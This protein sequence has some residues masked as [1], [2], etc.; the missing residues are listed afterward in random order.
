MVGFVAVA[1]SSMFTLF[2][3]ISEGYSKAAGFPGDCAREVTPTDESRKGKEGCFSDELKRRTRGELA[4][5]R[6]PSA[7]FYN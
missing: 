7:S 6:E 5:Q 3:A 4:Y 2:G 1:A